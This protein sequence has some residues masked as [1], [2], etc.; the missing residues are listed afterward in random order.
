LLQIAFAFDGNTATYRVQFTSPF[1]SSSQQQQQQQSNFS[2]SSDELQTMEI[3]FNENF[4]PISILSNSMNQI[5]MPTND[6]LS[7]ATAVQNRNTAMGAFEKML[8]NI[9]PRVLRDLVK[10][11]RLEQ[12]SFI[13]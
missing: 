5:I 11:I 2:W 9:H 8:S 10:I 13:I 4:F 1:D 6:I 12:V 7:L 3:F